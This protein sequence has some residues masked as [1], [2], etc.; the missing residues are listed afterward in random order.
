MIRWL[1]KRKV[2]ELLTKHGSTVA[3]FNFISRP[4]VSRGL[5][6]T[7][8]KSGN[9]R[10]HRAYTGD[11]RSPGLP[12]LRCCSL[13]PFSSPVHAAAPCA[14]ARTL[15]SEVPLYASMCSCFHPC[16]P[17]SPC[18]SPAKRS[19]TGT[20]WS[21]AFKWETVFAVTCFLFKYLFILFLI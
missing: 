19:R 12:A 6:K 21:V 13:L 20:T 1:H 14:R 16:G 18:A 8:S 11:A 3:Q 7:R 15:R 10:A 4:R 17:N 2:L 5:N 9:V